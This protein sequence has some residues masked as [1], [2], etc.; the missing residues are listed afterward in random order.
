MRWNWG[1]IVENLEYFS[2][3]LDDLSSVVGEGQTSFETV[4][5][6]GWGGGGGGGASGGRWNGRIPE[7]G[8]EPGVEVW[9]GGWREGW[10]GEGEGCDGL[11]GRC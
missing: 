8:T 9:D 5:F 2:Y 3:G 6:W 7:E 4:N 11:F 10:C 1:Y